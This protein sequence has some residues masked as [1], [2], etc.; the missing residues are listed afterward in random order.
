MKRGLRAR[1]CT[2][3]KQIIIHSQDDTKTT[4]TFSCPES[5]SKRKGHYVAKDL[6]IFPFAWFF[7]LNPHC[8]TSVSHSAPT[9][10]A[11]LLQRQALMHFGGRKK[12]NKIQI[13]EAYYKT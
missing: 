9:S 3:S 1:Q 13:M 7:T 8:S 11:P 6:V 12:H 5:E 2:E 10:K 4:K